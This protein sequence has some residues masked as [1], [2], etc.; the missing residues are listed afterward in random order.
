MMLF[1]YYTFGLVFMNAV[2]VALPGC[3]EEL[4]RKLLKYYGTIRGTMLTLF[5]STTGG[6]DWSD[7]AD[8]LWPI[9]PFYYIVFLFYVSVVS[10]AIVNLITGLFVDGAMK[11][12]EK[13]RIVEMQDVKTEA[14]EFKEAV[15]Q[16]FMEMVRDEDGVLDREELELAIQEP[17]MKAF[18]E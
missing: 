9:G 1:I 3:D 2:A 6:M 15:K 5:M 12:A 16:L 14:D 8:V 4:T 17:R 13:D 7:A 18:M 10:F 11:A